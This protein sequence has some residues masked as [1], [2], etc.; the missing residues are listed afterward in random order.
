MSY[1]NQDLTIHRVE[2]KSYVKNCEYCDEEYNQF[3]TKLWEQAPEYPH[4]KRG[5]LEESFEKA[6]HYGV[7]TVPL[8]TIGQLIRTKIDIIREEESQRW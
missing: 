5:S 1:P 7:G 4:V 3:I 2:H 6:K 8:G